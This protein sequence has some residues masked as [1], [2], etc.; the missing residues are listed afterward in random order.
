MDTG[1]KRSLVKSIENQN[2]FLILSIL[3][4]FVMAIFPN[5]A[6]TKSLKK[7]Q[8]VKIKKCHDGDTCSTYLGGKKI[9]VRFSGIDCPELKQKHG[10]IALKFTNSLVLDRDVDLICDGRSYDRITCT[11]FSNGINVNEELVKQG[12][13]FDSPKY[14][15][16]RYKEFEEAARK[17]RIGLWSEEKIT[18]PHC[19]RHPKIKQC[20]TNSQ[21]MP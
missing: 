15:K 9:K 3:C 20:K 16:R 14:S 5:N 21:Y 12:L 13:A 19:F 7:I 10:S 6:L 11:V 1:N 8:S 2:F 4:F 18:S 17:A